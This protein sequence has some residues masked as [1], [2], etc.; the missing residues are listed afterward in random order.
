[1]LEKLEDKV[2]QLLSE[3]K[4]ANEEVVKE[5]DEEESLDAKR[6]KTEKAPYNILI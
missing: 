5:G 2:G 6:Q 1:L 4:R 3:K